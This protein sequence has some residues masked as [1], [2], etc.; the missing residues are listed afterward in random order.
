[1]WGL[2][3]LYIELRDFFPCQKPEIL[4]QATFLRHWG[5][6]PMK[7][8]IS[9]YIRICYIRLG[10]SIFIHTQVLETCNE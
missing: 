1:M 8:H 2:D 6:N 7:K 9:H 3:Y 4:K 5:Q 10:F